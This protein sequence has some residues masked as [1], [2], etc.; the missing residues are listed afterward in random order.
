[1]D[2]ILSDLET[3]SESLYKENKY[4]EV[5][6]M[7]ST[8]IKQ[9]NEENDGNVWAKAYNNR[10]HAKYMAVNFD[11]ALE[12]Y[13]AALTR[14]NDEKLKGIVLF[15]RGTIKYRM[16]CKDD[17]LK[18]LENALQSDPDNEEFKEAV[19]KCKESK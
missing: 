18:D 17:A 14:V 1:M 3:K 11:D 4:K 13:E 8:F 19:T 15:N 6:D 9:L 12:D 5:S 7:F 16:G 2:T 10:G